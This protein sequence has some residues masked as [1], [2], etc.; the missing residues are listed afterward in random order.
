MNKFLLLVITLLV[1]GCW[2]YLLHGILTAINATELQWFIYYTYMPASIILI[3][4][5]HYEKLSE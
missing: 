2:F 3:S 5:T 4:V 1:I